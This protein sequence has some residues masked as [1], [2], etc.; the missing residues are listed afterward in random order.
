MRESSTAIGSLPTRQHRLNWLMATEY[1]PA[2]QLSASYPIDLRI[3]LAIDL[4]KC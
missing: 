1:S 3:D 2:S 4:P